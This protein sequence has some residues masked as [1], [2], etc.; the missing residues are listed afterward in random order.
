MIKG[1]WRY[2]YER[3]IFHILA[4]I[5]FLG[6]RRLH[7]QGRENVPATG[8]VILVGNHIATLDPPM[9]TALLRRHDVFPMAKAEAFRRRVA[10]YLLAG[11][12]AF[13]VV[14]H[15]AD[16]RAL[17]RALQVQAV[18]LSLVPPELRA[19]LSRPGSIVIAA[20][21]SSWLQSS[22]PCL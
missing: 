21:G 12:N 6:R 3:A 9:V 7:V 15:S 11:W 8:P 16:R 2:P 13:P 5:V 10:S 17:E 19:P 14:R 20:T 18:S 22:S 4:W 1:S